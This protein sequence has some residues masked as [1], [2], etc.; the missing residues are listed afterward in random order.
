MKK[1]KKDNRDQSVQESGIEENNLPGYPVYPESEDIYNNYQEE[2][3]INPEDIFTTEES[4]PEL[5]VGGSSDKYL[6]DELSGIDLDIP[7]S[8]MDDDMENIG[9]EDEENDYYSLG[10]DDH[11]DLEEDQGE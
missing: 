3:D 5:K 11:T 7:G 6:N 8:E 9:I 1:E 4:D 10:G 2:K